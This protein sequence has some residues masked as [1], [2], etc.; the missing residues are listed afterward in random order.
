MVSIISGFNSSA[1]E[2]GNIVPMFCRRILGIPVHI[3]ASYM[4]RNSFR[5]FSVKGNIH[6]GIN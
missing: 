1:Y 6:L 4:I 5:E 2:E 3:N